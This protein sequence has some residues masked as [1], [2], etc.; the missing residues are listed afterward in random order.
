MATAAFADQTAARVAETLARGLADHGL[1]PAPATIWGRAI[2]G[3][4]QH[5]ATWWIGGAD[6]TRGEA[7]D[8]LTDLVWVGIVGSVTHVPRRGHDGDD[9]SACSRHLFVYGTLMPGRLRWPILAPFA[10]GHRPGVATGA[11]YDSGNGWPVAV[12]GEGGEVPGVL[13]ELD[14][15]SCRRGAAAARRGRGHGDGHAAPHRGHDARRH[16]G[17]DVPLS[18]VGRGVRGDRALGRSGRR[19]RGDTGH[20]GAE[21][22]GRRPATAAKIAS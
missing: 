4:V 21:S 20:I 5:T 16:E 19:L 22:P 18:A 7:V 12:F 1:D 6:I 17:V 14:A 10:R 9:L 3:M 8:A 15:G 11:L 2:V 13:V